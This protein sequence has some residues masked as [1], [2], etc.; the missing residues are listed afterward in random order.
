MVKTDKSIKKMQFL[1][2][3]GSLVLRKKNAAVAYS[4]SQQLVIINCMIH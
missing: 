2:Q 1:W 4:N 3:E